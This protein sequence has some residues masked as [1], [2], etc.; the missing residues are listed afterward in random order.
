[1]VK[2]Y[3]YLLLIGIVALAAVLRF[4]HLASTP[5]SPS[6]DEVAWGYNSYTLSVD[7]R[8]EFGRFLPFTYLESFGDFKPPIYAYLGIIPTVLWGMGTFA[9]RFP[10]AF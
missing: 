2:K 9:A 6:W 5:P 10:S 3:K 4:Y 1:M 7:G 8:D